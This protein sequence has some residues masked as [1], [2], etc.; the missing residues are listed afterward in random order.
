MRTCLGKT[1]QPSFSHAILHPVLN[2]PLVILKGSLVILFRFAF[3]LLLALPISLYRVPTVAA[4]QT[5]T[6]QIKPERKTAEQALAGYPVVEARR[7][8]ISATSFHG[9]LDAQKIKKWL[10]IGSQCTIAEFELFL[11]PLSPQEVRLLKK[12]EQIP[13]PIVNRL[14]FEHLQGVLKE[15]GL[16][17]LTLEEQSQH[18]P[19]KHTTPAVENEL[20]GAFEC[21]FASVGPLH[22]SPR[23]GDVIIRMK[24]SVRETGWATPFSGMH[25][26]WAI[27][28]QP[29][30]KMQDLLSSGGELPTS[31]TNPMSLG[32]DDRLHYSHYIVTEKY[33]H[34]A[35]AYQAIL[36][37]RNL[38]DSEASQQVRQR[39]EALL[40]ET[41]PGKFWTHF[42]PPRKLKLSAE[43][44]A[45]RVPFG[46][47][48]AKFPNR[49]D[50]K[51]VTSI[52]V[53]ADKLA[54]VKAWSAAK[55][56]LHLIRAKPNGVD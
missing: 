36:V 8:A 48:E 49:L 23:Y 27:R 43:E 6:Q 39:F 55:P 24:D 46:Y 51:F 22:G 2:F 25:F 33:W 26:I 12:I 5:A 34:K 31:P 44:Q 10:E 41:D 15:G 1:R 17:S 21:V 37:L 35:L 19:F 9:K 18:V 54:E 47:L 7:H 29:A 28:N 14:H 50:M 20:F 16:I 40:A 11:E 53:S 30:R 4:Q 38:D 45:A 52:E 32:F 13:P 3:I 56:Y 42:I